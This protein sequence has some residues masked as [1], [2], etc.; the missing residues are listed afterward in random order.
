MKCPVCYFD[1]TKVVD[2]RVATDGLSIR[3]R[4]EC[5]KCNF[6]FS[7]Y[8]E[9]ELLDLAIVKRDGRRESYSREKLIS[10]LKKSF[11]KRPITEDNFKKL[12][13]SVERELQRLKKSEIT[14]RQIGAIVMKQLKKVDQVAYIRYASV[15]ESFKDAQEFRKELNKLIKEK[16]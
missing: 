1:D 4:R 3:R 2:S 14:S 16:K 13:H 9:V 12:V 15:Y 7:T 11:E 5:L 6:R 8:E 10:G